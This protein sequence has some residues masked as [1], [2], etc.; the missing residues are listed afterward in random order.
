MINRLAAAAATV[1]THGRTCYWP[2]VPGEAL[3]CR[4]M[5]H[6][7]LGLLRLMLGPFVLLLLLLL[8]LLL[9]QLL[10]APNGP[11]FHQVVCSS[12]GQHQHAW[13][14]GHCSDCC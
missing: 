4:K 11:Q 7:T 13:V 5:T 14:N 1:V 8:L 12:C 3:V 9:H 2:C 6:R 10:P